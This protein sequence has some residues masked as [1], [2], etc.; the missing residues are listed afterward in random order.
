[1][2]TVGAATPRGRRG[3][4][5]STVVNPATGEV[6]ATVAQS[7][8]DDVPRGRA[9][10]RGAARVGGARLRGSRADPAPRPEVD[11]R[12]HRPDRETIVSETGKTY[13]DALARRGRLRGLRLRLLGQ[14]RAE[15][16]GDEK[17][18]TSNPF[19]LG[20]KLVVRYRPRR[21]RR[22]DRAV[23]L[24]ADELLR[25]LHPG[26]RR[27]QRRRPEAGQLTPLT[28]QLM[29]EGLRE[30]GLPEDVFQVVA[31]RGDT[32]GAGRRRR[33]GHVHRLDRDRQEGDGARRRP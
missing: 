8:S 19:V 18:R 27:R 5:A 31:G 29:L 33:H 24:P 25:R 2:A 1:M 12:Q 9:R 13:E 17:I 11:D 10:P 28:S 15:V 32:A 21:R 7:T 3:C 16:P 22:R 23:E 26:A 20:R 4:R 30:C 6:I 14:A